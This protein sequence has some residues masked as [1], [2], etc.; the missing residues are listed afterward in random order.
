MSKIQFTDKDIDLLEQTVEFDLI[1]YNDNDD[2]ERYKSLLELH[3]NKYKFFINRGRFKT[4]DELT[5]SLIKYRD[6]FKSHSSKGNL[7]Y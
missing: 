3:I 6:I 4:Q 7:F 5:K 2:K 1:R